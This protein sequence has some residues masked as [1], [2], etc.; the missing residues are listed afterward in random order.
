MASRAERLFYA[1]LDGL[2]DG[3]LI[4]CDPAGRERTVD[5]ADTTPA[6]ASRSTTLTSTAG[7][8]VTPD[9]L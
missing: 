4:V 2:Q 1:L 8:C 5:A 3:S 9:S 7:C 6:F